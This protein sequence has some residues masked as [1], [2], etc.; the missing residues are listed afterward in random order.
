METDRQGDAD[1]DDRD[2][3]HELEDGFH[4]RTIQSAPVT[5]LT[6]GW[7]PAK[8]ALGDRGSLEDSLPSRPS[9]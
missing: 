6:G 9:R 3:E 1:G 4:T 2:A 8:D 5:T 7:T